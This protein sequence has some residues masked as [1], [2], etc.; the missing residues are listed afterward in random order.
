MGFI[1]S[2]RLYHPSPPGR[3]GRGPEGTTATEAKYFNEYCSR[4]FGGVPFG[5]TRPGRSGS[6]CPPSSGLRRGR[7]LSRRGAGESPGRQS[8]NSR[9]FRR[10]RG[11]R[12]AMS[13]GI[14][15]VHQDQP[16]AYAANKLLVAPPLD[17]ICCKRRA[18]FLLS[19][20]MLK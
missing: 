3:R 17:R 5:A 12:S 15:T 1:L 16:S 10:V 19:V 8:V 13:L 18:Q 11:V 9:V 6:G 2:R 20:R 7:A 14:L 4:R